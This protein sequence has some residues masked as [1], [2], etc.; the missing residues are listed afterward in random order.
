MSRIFVGQR[1]SLCMAQSVLLRRGTTQENNIAQG[2]G[3]SGN[4]SGPL[5]DWPD[6]YFA[7]GTPAPE[8]PKQLKWKSQREA[9]RQRCEK[10][11]D[12]VV[13]LHRNWE[14]RDKKETR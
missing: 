10:L 7:D 8:T 5:H 1:S 4:Q 3:R 2:R 6:F 11:Q 9:E 13:Q 12:E 14:E